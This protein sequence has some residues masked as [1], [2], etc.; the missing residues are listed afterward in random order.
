MLRRRFA[1]LAVAGG[2]VLAVAAAAVAIRHISSPAQGG[3]YAK[4][5]SAM[6]TFVTVSAYA[7]DER[8]GSAAIDAA[9]DTVTRLE[10]I[11]SHFEGESDVSRI[12][13]AAAGTPVKV[14][15][16]TIR[17]LTRSA[18]ISKR[19][20]GAFDCTVGPLVALW[21]AAGESGVLPN[22]AEI[23]TAR[24]KVSY[25]S[26]SIDA[27]NSTV[28]VTRAGVAVDL[29]SVGKGYIVKK[30]AQTM[31]AM[32]VTSGFVDGG[33]D[34]E[35]IG[36][37]ADGSL[38]RV[39]IQDPRDETKVVTTLYVAD[40]GVVTSGNYH[41][42][43]T[44]RGRRYSHIIDART[45]RPATEPASVTVVARDAAAAAGWPTALSVLGRD[46]AK[47]AEEAGVE[48]LMYFVEG[49]GLAVFQSPGMAKYQSEDQAAQDAAGREAPAVRGEDR[50]SRAE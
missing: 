46:G 15:P 36:G 33:G 10:R 29:S 19:T 43:E 28:T 5:V 50:E 37:N 12:N 40:R 21:K 26:L 49:D 27:A 11:I 1:K 24:E 45:G 18:E 2:V 14:S 48:Y 35:F 39:G 30:A 22:D 38:W 9:I 13:R 44:I 16:D 34:I 4:T 7:A 23:E 42:F 25:A 6:G 32:G 47:A 41:Q 3:R 31:R 20:Q 17:C 8:S